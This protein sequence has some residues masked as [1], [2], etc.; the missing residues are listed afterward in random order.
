[1]NGE[2]S[3]D[4]Y[5]FSTYG[6]SDMDFYAENSDGI[7][8]QTSSAEMALSEKAEVIQEKTRQGD[9]QPV[10]TVEQRR[11]SAPTSDW[12]AVRYIANPTNSWYVRS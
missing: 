1:M 2:E 12:D 11:F 10:P 5:G 9:L 3:T 7:H 4:D 6:P 8:I